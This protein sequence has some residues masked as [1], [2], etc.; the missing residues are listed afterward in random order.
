MGLCFVALLAV[1]RPWGRLATTLR[2]LPVLLCVVFLIVYFYF[3]RRTLTGGQLL[4]PTAY[5]SLW[6]KII[7]FPNALFGSHDEVTRHLLMGL[8]VIAL[9]TMALLRLRSRE[10]LPEEGA[11]GGSRLLRA[12]RLLCHYRF[13]AASLGYFVAYFIAPQTWTG[14]TMVHERFV[15]PAWALLALTASPR[16][17]PSRLA[18]MATA[19]LPIGML[20]LSWPQF[21]DSDRTYKNLDAII[22][23]IPMDSSVALAAVDRP[24]YRTRVYSASTGPART[25]AA[26]GGRV[27]IS[28]LISPLSP[29]QIR[30]E[31]RW[32][33]LDR[34]FLI[35]GSRDLRPGTDLK[36]FGY[37]IAQSRDPSVRD[38]IIQAFRPDAELIAVKGEWLLLRS[39]HAQLPMTSPDPPPEPFAETILQRV[40]YLVKKSKPGEPWP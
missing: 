18:K 20:L 8:G 11:A 40:T 21:V 19:G 1:A 10:E 37:V 28:I 6:E 12:Q 15:G 5:F 22:E 16:G 17:E 38:V 9:G 3:S 32:N 39:T 26:R 36:R 4:P 14:A 31:F 24:V 13:E 27:S 25:V 33:E 23:M 2:A 7:Y 29:V 35:S 30:E 34:R